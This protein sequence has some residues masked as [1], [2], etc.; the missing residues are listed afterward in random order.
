[1]GKIILFP[2]YENQCFYEGIKC[3]EEKHYEKA[4]NLFEK[5][6]NL[7]FFKKE[8]IKYL[9]DSHIELHHFDE[10]YRM[11]ENEFI[12]KNLDEEYL[13]KKYLY[14][15]FIE[16]QY[17]EV[18]E[19]INIYRNNQYISEN[20]KAYLDEL[21]KLIEINKSNKSH[22][23]MKYF[24][25]NDFNDHIQIIL[26]LDK[27]DVKKY[28]LEIKNFCGNSKVDS[29]V[30]YCLLKYLMDNELV[31]EMNYTNYFSESYTI[32][33]NN[34]YDILKNKFFLEPINIVIDKIDNK[35]IIKPFINNIWLDFCVK[36]YPHLID[37][38]N[39]ASA[40]LH[41]LVLRSLNKQ[42]NIQEICEIYQ[43]DTN[44][45]FYY[46]KT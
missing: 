33:K 13:L 38:V 43:T 26:N 15:M 3:F 29:F 19:L 37:N 36:Y 30:K 12:D 10:V 9:I 32:T 14:T 22:G 31:K 2:K 11:I 16:E 6:L 21:Q 34:Y 24:L 7:N 18:M 39:L 46:F 25:S 35:S 28:F 27:L 8:C 17:Y 41:V 42:I 4:I 44:Q 40:L 20:L 23:M 45:L 1:M 5:A